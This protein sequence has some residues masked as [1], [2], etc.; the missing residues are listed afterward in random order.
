ME[1]VSTGEQR[2]YALTK[3]MSERRHEYFSKVRVAQVISA[4]LIVGL[5]WWR[6]SSPSAP[7]GFKAQARNNAKIIIKDYTKLWF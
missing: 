3:A 1:F 2:T 5:L 7:K 6:S 4:A